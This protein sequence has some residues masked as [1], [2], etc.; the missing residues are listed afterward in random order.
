MFNKFTNKSQEVIINAQIIAQ[1]NG[2]QQIESL[3]IL[4]SLLTQDESLI[5][6]VLER[7][8]IM[9]E[10]VE[11]K[12]I[13][14]INKLPKATVEALTGTVQGTAEVAIIFERA[15]K[16]ADKMGDEYISTEHILLALISVKSEAKNILL[17]IGVEY[18]E[19]L[20]ILAELRGTQKIDSPD[21]ENKYKV[22][23]KYAVN[24]TDKAR[25]EKLDP[26]IGRDNEIRRIMQVLSRRTKNNPVLIGEAGTGKTAI[27]EGLAQRIVSGDVPETLK[28]KELLSLDLGAMVAGAKFRGEFEDRLK[29]LLRE[30]QSQDGKI[31]LFIDELHTLVG[32]GASE[33]AMDASN[34]LKPALA[35]GELK[36]IGAT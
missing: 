5:K 4:A 17:H 14:A 9:P 20:K 3:H 29:A 1:D 28:N 31:I 6:P 15:K 36:A 26:V 24:L 34:M 27:I 12:V 19:V 18:D 13:R 16:E 30:I 25:Q 10:A 32:A 8:K 33:G 11:D 23:E 22:L 2:Q 35:R 7:L 21:P